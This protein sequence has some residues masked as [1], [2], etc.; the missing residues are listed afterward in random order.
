MAAEQVKPL[1]ATFDIEDEE[2]EVVEGIG[3][4]PGTKYKFSIEKPPQGKYM[5]YSAAKGGLF[6]L[7]KKCPEDL[8]QQ[9]QKHPDQFEIFTAGHT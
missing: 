3:F 7:Q 5:Q 8:A 2:S 1:Q 4:E 9:Y 6:V